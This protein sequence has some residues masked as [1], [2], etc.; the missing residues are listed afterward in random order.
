MHAKY[1][2]KFSDST[3]L[4]VI[5]A[6]GQ[7]A[8]DFGIG[9]LF[10]N[11]SQTPYTGRV[12]LSQK[13]VKGV[14]ANIGA[15]VIV[16]PYELHLRFPPPRRPGVPSGGPLDVPQESLQS[17]SRTMPAFYTEWEIVPVR[18]TR[19]VPGLRA[20]YSSATENW[21]VSPRINVKQDL[22]RGF[23]RTSLK[24]G[25]GLFYQPPNPL[26]TDPVFGQPG[27]KSNRSVHYDVGVEQELS[28]KI[29]L[30]TD[31]FYKALDRLVVTG[32]GNSGEGTA[33][34]A[35][36]LLKYKSDD[37]FFGWVAYTLSRSERRDSPTDPL[38]AFQY[39]QT[40][41]LTV[42]GSYKLGRG[43]RLGGRFRF[44]SGNLFTT[45]TQGAF[46]ATTGA[47]L[48]APTYPPYGKRLPPFHQLDLRVDKTWTYASWK[49]TFYI[50]IQ[51]VYIHQSPEG[52]A[53]NYNYTQSG[54]IGGLPILPSLGL[55]GEF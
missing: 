2:N 16:A 9:A 40:H 27:L 24:G 26:E 50:D 1:Q 10:F 14:Q 42:L 28:R 46:D 19:L 6:V 37:K 25:V 31:V 3:E 39:D 4:R 38:R 32:L 53:Y 18:G 52:V 35:E 43:W 55:R 54:Y 36:W 30:S 33:Y 49:L 7:D 23:P 8:I 45:D 20:D 29:E 44:V 41:I 47:N 21:D 34:G 13:I 51:N 15:D 12:E 5:G 48:A 22:S 17:G 11:I